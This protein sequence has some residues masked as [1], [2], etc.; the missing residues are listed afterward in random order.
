MDSGTIKDFINHS[1]IK[2]LG[3]GMRKLNIPRRIFNIDEME[4][5]AERLTHC[6]TLRI[7]KGDQNHLQT[8]YITALSTDRMILKYPWLRPFN[9]QIDWEGGR[10]LGP[11]IQVETCGLGKQRAAILNRML[12][13]AKTSSAWEE[14]DEIII[15]AASAHILQQ[16]VIEVNKCKPQIITLL[17]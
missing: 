7:H 6:C 14:G 5:I 3:I 4:N 10:I 15:M 11:K 12:K 17:A 2:R 8:F 1:M 9:L 13:A 16:W